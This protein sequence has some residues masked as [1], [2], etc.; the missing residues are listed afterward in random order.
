MTCP[1]MFLDKMGLYNYFNVR[2]F[3]CSRLIV[4]QM[5]LGAG[6]LCWV[7]ACFTIEKKQYTSLRPPSPLA[8]FIRMNVTAHVI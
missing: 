3:H 2:P 8:F 1:P 4:S 7:L 6:F 5:S